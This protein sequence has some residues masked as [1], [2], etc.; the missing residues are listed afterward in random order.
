M[1]IFK[2]EYLIPFHFILIQLY[3]SPL[4]AMPNP[5][6][7]DQFVEDQPSLN[8]PHPPKSDDLE[9]DFIMIGGDEVGLD[10]GDPKNEEE[11]PFIPSGH[12]TSED[13]KLEDLTE[14]G[15]QLASHGVASGA[16][17]L[18]STFASGL[19]SQTIVG[20]VGYKLAQKVL[21]PFIDQSNLTLPAWLLPAYVKGEDL[22]NKGTET[23]AK[24]E[25]LLMNTN[26]S[27]VQKGVQVFIFPQSADEIEMDELET[28]EDISSQ[29]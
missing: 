20:F 15:K 6:E 9:E 24:G 11:I 1:N 5:T 25:D 21:S 10:E 16:S 29:K 22:Y 12:K 19:L 26:F 17:Y 13:E 23:L 28:R 7:Y 8:K 4:C 18:L 2:I 27:D 14:K 3:I